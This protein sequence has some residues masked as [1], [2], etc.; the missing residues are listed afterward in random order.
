MFKYVA[1]SL[2]GNK[3]TCPYCNTLSQQSRTES[4]YV[5][6]GHKKIFERFSI[7]NAYIKPFDITIT[8]CQCCEKY[9]IWHNG[10]MLL[11]SKSDIPMP[12]EDMPNDIKELYNE[13]RSVFT[14]SKIATAAL[15]RLAL[16]KMCIHLGEKGK[17]INDDIASLVSKGLPVE[18][19]KSLDYI[20]VTGNNS[21]HPGEMN[22]E[23]DD[24]VCLRLFSML[25]FIVD[26]MIVQPKEI[27][28]AFAFLPEKAKVAIEKRDSKKEHYL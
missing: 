23:D 20:R 13:A 7:E 22:I 10:K 14:N 28:N 5:Y 4:K 21:V 24:N 27:E 15:L 6:N 3:F 26:R 11:P 12:L 19:Q 17:N 9:H 8:T 25:N 2:V 18:V 16:Q 1:P